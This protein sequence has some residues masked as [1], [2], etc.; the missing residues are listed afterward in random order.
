MKSK[1]A[2]IKLAEEMLEKSSRAG[3]APEYRKA[4]AMSAQAYI[5]LAKLVDEEG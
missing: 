5:E 1:Q 3:T 4:F 2:Y